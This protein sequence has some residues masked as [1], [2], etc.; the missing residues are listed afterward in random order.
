MRI[1]AKNFEQ[2]T[3]VNNEKVI[4]MKHDHHH[5]E[6][7]NGTKD[8]G[9]LEHHHTI[10]EEIL[11]HLPFA[12]FSVALSMVFLSLISISGDQGAAS[13][14]H[15]IAYKLF[16]NFHYLHL[17]FAGTGT[18]LMFRKYSKSTLGGMVVGFCVPA[19]FC[20]MSDAIL[21]YLG[22]KF[23]NLPMH[24]HWCFLK[25]LDTVLPFLIV[26]I[27][28]GWVMSG[29]ERSRQV[30]YSVSFHFFHIFISS[31]ASILYLVSFGFQDW[32]TRMGFVFLYMIVVVLIPCTLADVVIPALFGKAKLGKAKK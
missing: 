24:F 4:I 19:V 17:L 2:L 6:L 20:T 31:M 13:G 11:C 22:G 9:V 30:F 23:I 10:W 3:Y 15:S 18:I 5:T 1:T 27:I 28:N 32:W 21:P 7:E 16:H 25:H 12:I 8:H 14:H 26:G 29:H